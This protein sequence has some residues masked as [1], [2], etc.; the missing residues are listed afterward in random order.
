MAAVAPAILDD[1]T[2]SGDTPATQIT[3]STLERVAS[4]TLLEGQNVVNKGKTEE[5]Q[6]LYI[7]QEAVAMGVLM[8]LMVVSNSVMG[9]PR[10]EI[11]DNV[12]REGISY[13]SKGDKQAGKLV[14]QRKVVRTEAYLKLNPNKKLKAF[15]HQFKTIKVVPMVVGNEVTVVEHVLTM[16]K[17]SHVAVRLNEEVNLR[18][19]SEKRISRGAMGIQKGLKENAR[20]GLLMK[21][22]YSPRVSRSSV[23]KWVQ[24]AQPRVDILG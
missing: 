13:A 8:V 22:S 9:S 19:N 15:K 2:Y 23:V 7:V 20:K 6:R 21:K 11:P 4:P 18:I 1:K 14:E 12:V 5:D 16:N 10:S 3:P 17:G 24:S